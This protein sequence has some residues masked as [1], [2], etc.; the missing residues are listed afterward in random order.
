M[1]P[2]G[3]YALA[4]LLLGA[5]LGF[6]QSADT[7]QGVLAVGQPREQIVPKP[8]LPS[9]DGLP[10][11][12]VAFHPDEPP[13]VP[14][15]EGIPAASPAPAQGSLLSVEAVGPGSVAPDQPLAYEIIVR[16]AGTNTLGR[17]HVEDVLPPG[18]K[19]RSA[20]P[21][22]DVQNDRLAWNLGNLDPGVEKRIKVEIKPGPDGEV[23]ITPTATFTLA[24]PCRTRIVRPPF[25]VTQT[26]AE[27]APRGPVT[28]QIH[29][30]NYSDQAINN[31]VLHDTLPVGLLRLSDFQQLSSKPD[32]VAANAV[33]PPVRD[34]ETEIATL[35]PGET[36]TINLETGA[37]QSGRLTNHVTVQAAGGWAANSEASILVTETPLTV[38]L[39]A[40][41][42]SMIG[43]DA[44]CRLEVTNPGTTPARNVRV[45]QTVPDGVEFLNAST[46]GMMDAARRTVY[47][48]LA[49]LPAG[50]KQTL[51]LKMR[52]KA[53]GDW[54]F[55]T[56]ATAEG[57]PEATAIQPVHLEGTPT[58]SLE[59][60]RHDPAID[61]GAESVYEV[62][63]L[64]LG[65][66]ATPG[67]SLSAT[68]SAGLLLLSAEGP[69]T[70]D[71]KA[72][73]IVFA[74]LPQ[75]PGRS[76]TVYRFHVKGQTA[77]DW[78]LTVQATAAQ[79]T[80]PLVQEVKTRV[81]AR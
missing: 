36:K 13:A 23:N 16:N 71:V 14:A 61:L 56:T 1:L 5:A 65:T 15:P 63:V 72:T 24:K 75:L 37:V 21:E 18:A 68:V 35:A 78:G 9:I 31:I 22:A 33:P 76:G 8:A 38:R 28:F 69:T 12:P 40:P 66:V 62:R 39:D 45:T 59:I 74:P 44:D 73:Q 19:L 77:G 53:P 46:A 81:V 55:K 6:A 42:Q 25:A 70:V 4:V 11:K 20:E 17:V 27:T 41:A 57:A 32:S 34:V 30:A 80:K 49:T 10:I 29:V 67:V 7:G 26:V 43:Q 54:L 3:M 50:Q 2:R 79:M 64:N 58:L 47:W 51:T 60:L 48:S 52:S